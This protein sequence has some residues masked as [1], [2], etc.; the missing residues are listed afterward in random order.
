MYENRKTACRVKHEN[1]ISEIFMC[2]L[3]VKQG[4]AFTV[5]VFNVY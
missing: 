1:E 3:G 2:T 5:S 4:D